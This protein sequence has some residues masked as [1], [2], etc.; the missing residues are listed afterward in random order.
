MTIDVIM[1]VRG[2]GSMEDLWAFND[3]SLARVIARS[4]VPVVSG[5]GHET[6]F[7]I[8]DFVADLRAPTPSAAAELAICTRQELLD[9]IAQSAQKTRR[10]MQYRINDAH[11]RLQRQG[12][13]RATGLLQRGIGRKMQRVDELDYRLRDTLRDG[14]QGRRWRLQKA[15]IRLKKMDLRLRFAASRRRVEAAQALALRGIAARLAAAHRGLFPLTAKLEQLSPL[16]VLERGYAIVQDESGHV[17]KDAAG[18][19]VES[20]LRILL[21][22]GKLKARVTETIPSDSSGLPS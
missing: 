21:A 10:A 9:R 6:D 2:G 22:K 14:L 3:E 11:R 16:K 18:T 1:L 17:L 12:I 5:I 20:T 13:E 8:A 7:T 19:S 4:P 15:E